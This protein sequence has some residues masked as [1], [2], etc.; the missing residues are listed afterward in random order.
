MVSIANSVQSYVSLKGTQEVYAGP[1]ATTDSKV[2]K[3]QSSPVTP[4]SARTFGTWTAISSIVRL[5]AA[6]HICDPTIYEICMWTFAIAF[7]HFMSEWLVFGTARWSRGLAGPVFVAT[8]TLAWMV[9][10]RNAYVGQ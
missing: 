7:M 10:Q 4:L 8:G 3:E 2:G 6:Y 1:A 9:V 5:Y